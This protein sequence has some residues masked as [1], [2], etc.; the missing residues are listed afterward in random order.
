MQDGSTQD[1]YTKV[2]K[3]VLHNS[4]VKLKHV[5]EEGLDHRI[6]TK[7]E[8]DAMDPEGKTAAKFYCTFKVH[9]THE[10]MSAPPERPIVS[11]CG[12]MMENAS[13]FVE[14]HM[15]AHGKQHASYL[16]DTPDFLRHIDN[17]NKAGKLPENAVIVTWDVIGLFTNIPHDEGLNSVRKTL[18]ESEQEV[19]DVP[20]EYIIRILE[21]ILENNIF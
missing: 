16:E 4:E 18:H 17:L 7:S 19:H 13:Q 5:L 1:Y 11:A 15:K 21:I 8:Y 20:T 9:K 3:S 12:S 10:P 6:I 2:D 14:H